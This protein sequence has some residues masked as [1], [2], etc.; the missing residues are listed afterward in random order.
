[1]ETHVENKHLGHRLIHWDSDDSPRRVAVLAV[2]GRGQNPT[3]MREQSAR[4]QARGVRFYAPRA[5]GDTW[6]PNPFLEPLESNQPDLTLALAAVH[7]QVAKI[8][9]DGFPLDRIVLWGFSQGAC[10]LSH[11]VLTNRSAFG[12]AIFH[13]GGYLGAEVRVEP[14]GT[15]LAGMPVVI[16][17]ID[18]DPWVPSYRVEQTA[19]SLTAV[20]ASVDCRIDRGREHG[21]TDEACAAAAQLLDSLVRE[22]SR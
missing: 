1:M 2:H 11:Y 22:T 17:S 8:E 3:F 14:A 4:M 15:P 6:Y 20:G 5:G 21:I 10:L 18:Q 7:A 13:T 12:G 16:R 9:V 19:E